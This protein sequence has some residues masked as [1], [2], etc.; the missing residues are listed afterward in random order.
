M[1]FKRKGALP[2]EQIKALHKRSSIKCLRPL[3]DTQIQPASMDLRL[4]KKC[5]EVEASFLPGHKK[6][7]RQKLSKLKKREID[8]GDFKT[9]AKGNIYII[10]IQEELSLPDN[11][12]AVA[13]AKSS[14]GRLDILTRLISDNSSCF[15]R[16]R[17]G[18][19]GKVYVEIAPISFS[20]TIKEGITLNLSLIHI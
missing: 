10:Q 17:K 4:S 15:D 5:W 2:A 8:I 16:I 19:K 13:N 20:I 14:T 12:S 11:I 6:T 7:V 18:Y 3:T 9:L 1:L